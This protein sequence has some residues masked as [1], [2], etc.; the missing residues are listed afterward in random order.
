M[1]DL[2]YDGFIDFSI[3]EEDL[4]AFRYLLSMGL[5]QI[6]RPV[7]DYEKKAIGIGA[8]VLKAMRPIE[9]E[10]AAQ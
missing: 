10:I 4:A 8:R 6:R 3:P 2:E 5:V 9:R 1:P 7:K